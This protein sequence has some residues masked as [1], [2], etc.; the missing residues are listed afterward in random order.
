M[1]LNLK[2]RTA[3]VTGGSKGIGKAIALSLAM[4]N[5]NVVITARDK[6]KLNE[7]VCEIKKYGGNA[8]SVVSNANDPYSIKNVIDVTIDKYGG[9]DSLE[10]SPV[11]SVE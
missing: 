3:I 4:E 8:F 6:E 11:F 2:D 1:N 9:L 5:V 7:C 10:I